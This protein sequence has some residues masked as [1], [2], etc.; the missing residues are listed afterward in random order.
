MLTSTGILAEAD[1]LLGAAGYKVVRDSEALAALG[2]QALLAEDRY[3]VVAVA[4]YDTWHALLSEWTHAQG[5][6]VE[7]MSTR[8]KRGEPKTW[9]GYLVCLTPA[10]TGDDEEE[11]LNDIR[12]NTVRIRKLVA[13][14]TQLRTLKDVERVFLTLMPL[15]PES[16]AGTEGTFL[17]ELPAILE[18]RGITSEATRTLTDAFQRRQPLLER[19]D[20][21]LHSQ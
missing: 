16:I 9:D 21:Q 11:R 15:E 13:T 1:R 8:M 7:G 6:L 14:G 3:G 2:S 12:R 4:V 20:E 19:L 17:E 5:A 18:T 10:P